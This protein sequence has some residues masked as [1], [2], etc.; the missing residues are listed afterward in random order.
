VAA[1]ITEKAHAL[2]EQCLCGSEAQ[3]IGAAEIFALHLR[4]ASFRAFCEQG[5]VHLFDD[6]SV[7]VREQVATCFHGFEG[8]QLGDYR[9][10]AEAFV[11]S[12]AFV[13]NPSPVIHAL[14]ITEAKLPEI[15]CQACEA[16]LGMMEENHLTREKVH[17]DT[18]GKLLLRVYSQ[19]KDEA[20]QMRCLNLIDHLLQR[21][22][23][24]LGHVL[25]AYDR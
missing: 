15:T 14:E 9:E 22:A 21:G 3:R 17:E 1:L 6:P 5:L 20:L 18:V 19:Q 13:T 4:L 23:Y 11:Q 16:C 24:S 10:V 12:Q 7:K 2:A 8:A 25:A